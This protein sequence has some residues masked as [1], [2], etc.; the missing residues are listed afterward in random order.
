MGDLLSAFRDSLSFAGVSKAEA[1]IPLQQ[2]TP[3]GMVHTSFISG[4]VDVLLTF[5]E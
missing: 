5:G 3:E 4:Y 2:T 1:E